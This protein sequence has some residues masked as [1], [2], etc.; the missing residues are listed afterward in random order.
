LGG[1]SISRRK[2]GTLAV[3]LTLVNLKSLYEAGYIKNLRRK[4]GFCIGQSMA[5]G[6]VQQIPVE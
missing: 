2:H 4:E 6:R 1:N 3:M 5:H